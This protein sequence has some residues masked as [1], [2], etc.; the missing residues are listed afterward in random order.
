MMLYISDDHETAPPWARGTP[1]WTVC[2]PA[3]QNQ[4]LRLGIRPPAP[5]A[6]QLL[7]QAHMSVHSRLFP[8]DTLCGLPVHADRVFKKLG[9]GDG[10]CDV[11]ARCDRSVHR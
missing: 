6:S 8:S 9:P 10:I 1:R 5:P 3:K 2:A 7:L 4:H 11:G